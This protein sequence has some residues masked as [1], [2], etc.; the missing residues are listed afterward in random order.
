MGNVIKVKRDFYINV[1]EK[2]AP[3]TKI[4]LL[5]WVLLYKKYGVDLFYILNL[6][7]GLNI[8]VPSHRTLVEV[9][10]EVKTNNLE[11]IMEIEID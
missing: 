7:A 9:I 2:L 11:G 8:K 5:A 10:K 1:L 3:K 6:M 4:D